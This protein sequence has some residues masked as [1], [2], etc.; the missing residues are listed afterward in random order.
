VG[1][2]LMEKSDLISQIPPNT[3]RIGI[4]TY[5]NGIELKERF[6]IFTP[7]EERKFGNLNFVW[8]VKK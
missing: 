8:M 6:K 4:I 2:A 1:T 3:K 5:K 7:K